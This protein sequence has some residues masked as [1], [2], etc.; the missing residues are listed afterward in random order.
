M[1]ENNEP[2]RRSGED[3]DWKTETREW[4]AAAT[5][6]ACFSLALDER[7]GFNRNHRH[8]AGYT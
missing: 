8:Q 6:L 7:Q 1:N 4:S 3:W 2:E 5:D